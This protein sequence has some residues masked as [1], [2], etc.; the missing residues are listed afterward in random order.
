MVPA[1]G[2]I[3]TARRKCG[4]ASM[5]FLADLHFPV[6]SLLVRPSPPESIPSGIG[7]LFS[8]LPGAL[9]FTSALSQCRSPPTS[10]L[11][12]TLGVRGG[13]FTPHGSLLAPG[14]EAT[15]LLDFVQRSV[16]NTI[17]LTPTHHPDSPP[18]L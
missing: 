2:S 16:Q 3:C 7:G 10:D 15:R 4:A 6:W 5:G 14:S 18:S 17:P 9:P 1:V 11:P 13:F 8:P 12:W